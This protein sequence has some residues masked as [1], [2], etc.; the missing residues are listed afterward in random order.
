MKLGHHP[1]RERSRTFQILEN[2][3]QCRDNLEKIINDTVMRDLENRRLGVL[4]DRD[5]A[6]RGSHSASTTGRDAPTDPPIASAS[7][8]IKSKF[9]FC[10]RPRPPET[11]I[12]AELRSA[13]PFCTP[14]RSRIFLRELTESAATFTTSALPPASRSSAGKAPGDAVAKY[15]GPPRT[16]VFIF[17]FALKIWRVRIR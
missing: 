1:S 8:K 9:S 7:S 17:I 6:S 14:V 3:C 13:F 12:D 10:L 2:F 16:A 15:G 11:M 4:V 5:D